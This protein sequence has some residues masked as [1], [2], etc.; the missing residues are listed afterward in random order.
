MSGTTQTSDTAQ[1]AK[2]RHPGL[3]GAKAPVGPGRI[4][5]VG[6]VLA[7]LTV[8]IGLV[9]VRDALVSAGVLSGTSWIEGAVDG[10]DGL[11]AQWWMVPVGALMVGLGIWLLWTGLRPRPIRAVRLRS[12][13]GVFLRPQDVRVVAQHAAEDVDGVMSATAT[14]SRRRVRVTA[15]VTADDGT[16]AD[17]VQ[18]AVEQALS[19]LDPVPRVKVKTDTRGLA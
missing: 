14:A 8:A 6:V 16:I 5:L 4:S 13:T 10:L 12:P 15:T 7:V 17:D 18:N 19:A 9:G 1:T 11:K 2:D 3:T